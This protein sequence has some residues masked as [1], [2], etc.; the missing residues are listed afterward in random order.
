MVA[1]EA[2]TLGLTGVLRYICGNMW[3]LGNWVAIQGFDE[4]E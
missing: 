1:F 4:R 2:D 3:L